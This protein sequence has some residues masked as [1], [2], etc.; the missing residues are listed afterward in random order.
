MNVNRPH[1]TIVPSLF[2]GMAITFFMVS[3]DELVVIEM[4]VLIFII[5]LCHPIL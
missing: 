4:K 1:N 2:G 3:W 5:V